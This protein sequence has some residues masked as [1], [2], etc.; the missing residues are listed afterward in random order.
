MPSVYQ[1]FLFSETY[2]WFSR[3]STRKVCYRELSGTPNAVEKPL[4][5]PRVGDTRW[6]P[7]RACTGEYDRPMEGT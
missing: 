1:D 2:N 5:V 3:F 6:L 7:K 4:T